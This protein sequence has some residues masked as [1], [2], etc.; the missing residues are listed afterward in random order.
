MPIRELRR[1]QLHRGPNADVSERRPYRA[2]AP[3]SGD[4]SFVEESLAG[5]SIVKVAGAFASSEW[6]VTCPSVQRT[7]S[8]FGGVESVQ[9]KNTPGS[10]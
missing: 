8:V 9:P 4:Y 1:A 2:A 6:D 7:V 10:A 3:F 5:A